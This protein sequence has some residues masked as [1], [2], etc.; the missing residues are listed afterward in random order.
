MR[1]KVLPLRPEGARLEA[2]LLGATQHLR[3]ADGHRAAAV[4][5]LAALAAT[6]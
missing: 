5:D 3:D 1:G 2:E 4:A 6:P